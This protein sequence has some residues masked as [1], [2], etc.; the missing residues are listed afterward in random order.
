MNDVTHKITAF[1][2]YSN[3]ELLKSK[4]KGDET[5]SDVINALIK[6]GIKK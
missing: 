2:T 5:I 6:K 4:I 3:I 1:L